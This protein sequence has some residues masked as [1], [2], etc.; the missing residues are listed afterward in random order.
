[1]ANCK[2]LCSILTLAFEE[3]SHQSPAIDKQTS[4]QQL[5]L[6]TPTYSLSLHESSA[7]SVPVPIA[8]P[9]VTVAE[10]HVEGS[11]RAIYGRVASASIPTS[12][13]NY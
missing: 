1:M 4:G 2:H 13:A 7:P 10:D 8:S 6:R 5:Q 3:L 9:Q 11:S 12:P